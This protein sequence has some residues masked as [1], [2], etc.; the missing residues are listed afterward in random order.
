[1]GQLDTYKGLLEWNERF[2]KVVVLTVYLRDQWVQRHLEDKRLATL[3]DIPGSRTLNL[4]KE[5]MQRVGEMNLPG[6][7]FNCAC[8]GFSFTRK[9]LSLQE[10]SECTQHKRPKKRLKHISNIEQEGT[11]AAILMTTVTAEAVKSDN[12]PIP[13]HLWDRRVVVKFPWLQDKVGGLIKEYDTRHNFR[14]LR[15]FFLKIWRWRVR[16]SFLV[17]LKDTPMTKEEKARNL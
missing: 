3:L 16:R 2:G 15:R 5:S 17:W 12:A 8:R 7:I 13:E 9:P 10:I 11:N 1:M 14:I 4:D 6:K